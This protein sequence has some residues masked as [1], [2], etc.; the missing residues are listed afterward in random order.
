VTAAAEK[1]A[2]AL[3]GYATSGW[4]WEKHRGLPAG[5]CERHAAQY[6]ILVANGGRT[7]GARRI[8]DIL[9]FKQ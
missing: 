7:L 4:R 6:R 3:G 2:N 8:I 5:A 1:A 9:N